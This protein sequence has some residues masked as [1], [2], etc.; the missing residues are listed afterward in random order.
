MRLGGWFRLWIVVSLLYLVLVILSVVLVFPEEHFRLAFLWWI[1]PVIGI[2][3]LG[4][5]VGWVY[6][7]FRSQ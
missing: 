3:V 1:I 6:R 7:G 5:A 2:Y 4:W